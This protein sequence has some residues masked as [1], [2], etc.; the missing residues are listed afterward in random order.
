MNKT[1]ENGPMSSMIKTLD[2][3]EDPLNDISHDELK[4]LLENLDK[5]DQNHPIKAILI[6]GF[7]KSGD[8][9]H[10]DKKKLVTH[11]HTLKLNG[12]FKPPEDKEETN[13]P[14]I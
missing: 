8:I 6:K 2:E 9:S 13:E 7:K 4:H 12:F 5:L 3:F 10:S 1:Q 14:S 11:I